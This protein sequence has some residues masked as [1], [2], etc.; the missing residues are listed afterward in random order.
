MDIGERETGLQ[1]CF[2]SWAW[3]SHLQLTNRF[4]HGRNRSRMMA[5]NHA[6]GLDEIVA[7][8][9]CYPS[10]NFGNDWVISMDHGICDLSFTHN[11]AAKLSR[12]GYNLSDHKTH[13]SWAMNIYAAKPSHSNKRTSGLRFWWANSWSLLNYIAH[14]LITE[15]NAIFLQMLA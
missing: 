5:P 11:A 2:C 9:R 12:P 10:V 6:A 14:T 13:A 15:F 3:W 4:D 8:S 7:T 1:L